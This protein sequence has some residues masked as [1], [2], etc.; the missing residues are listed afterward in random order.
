MTTPVNSNVPVDTTSLAGGDYT[1]TIIL[2]TVFNQLVNMLT[3][4][5]DSAAAQANRLTFLSNWQQAYTNLLGQLPTFIANDGT[6]ISGTSSA[7]MNARDDL[8]K[9]NANYTQTLQNRQS[10]V[11]DAAKSLQS[12]VSQSNDAVNQQSSLGTSIIQELSTLLS[13]VYQ[14]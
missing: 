2:N 6:F 13:T 4:L 1:S 8:N 9:I 10:V 7:D 12:V 5:Q 14:S 11:S 3:P